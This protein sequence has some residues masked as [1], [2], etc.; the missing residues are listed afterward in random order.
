[1]KRFVSLRGNLNMNPK[2]GILCVRT[3]KK[4][5]YC[6]LVKWNTIFHLKMFYSLHP[7]QVLN[8]VIAWGLGPKARSHA[9]KYI[10]QFLNSYV[11]NCFPISARCFKFHVGKTC[12]QLPS[13]TKLFGSS[14][15]SSSDQ[16]SR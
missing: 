13:I 11:A 16:F 2:P 12:Y 7:R 3:F 10:H 6:L 15:L 4:I 5:G 14:V 9:G 1:M 8:M